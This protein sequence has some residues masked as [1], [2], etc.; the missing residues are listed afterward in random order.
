MSCQPAGQVSYKIAKDRPANTFKIDSNGQLQIKDLPI[1]AVNNSVD[2]EVSEN[3]A[4]SEDWQSKVWQV[5]ANQ[6]IGKDRL[7]VQ[8]LHYTKTLGISKIEIFAHY[9]GGQQHILAFGP[10]ESENEAYKFFE[11]TKQEK[12]NLFPD[13]FQNDNIRYGDDLLDWFKIAEDG[14]VIFELPDTNNNDTL[15]TL[16]NGGEADQNDQE[17]ASL[18]IQQRKQVQQ[19][20]K[21]ELSMYEGRID[22]DFGPATKRAIK[23]YQKYIYA[24]ETGYLTDAQY[25]EI[26]EYAKP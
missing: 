14:S 10:F 17:V 24:Q 12:G 13:K 16:Q 23:A 4:V 18:D 11:N 2:V 25:Q 20:L 22:G 8:K 9:Q 21:E 19:I 1:V 5:Q 15:E 7:E 3:R 26:L 6:L